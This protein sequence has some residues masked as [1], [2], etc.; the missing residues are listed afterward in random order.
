[1][2]DSEKHEIIGALLDEFLSQLRDGHQPKIDDFVARHPNYEPQIRQAFSAVLMVEDSR[3]L[4]DDERSATDPVS[5]PFGQPER[6][7]EFEIIREI[8]R[9]GMG[10][11]FEAVQSSLDRRVAIKILKWSGA[12][13]AQSARFLNEAQAAARLHHTNIVPVFQ[14][15]QCDGIHYYAMQLI[16]G[17][18]LDTALGRLRSQADS[19]NPNESPLGKPKRKTT[20]EATLATTQ[21]SLRGSQNS[22]L[23]GS[24]KRPDRHPIDSTSPP[25]S[26][27]ANFGALPDYQDRSY[28]RVVSRIVAQAAEALEYAHQS[29]VLH[30]DIKP[31]N[32]ILAAD[33]HVWLTDF[34]LAKI[35]DTSLTETG[36]IAGTLQYMAPER[37]EGI[38]NASCD[39]FSLGLTLFELITLRPVFDAPDH[40]ALIGQ[41]LRQRI[42]DPRTISPEIPTDL[43]L[44]TMKATAR[45][46]S[47]RYVSAGEFARDLNCFLAGQPISAR[48][49]TRLD[50]VALWAKRNPLVASLTTAIGLLLL[51][52][53]IGSAIAAAN[54]NQK[55]SQI[56]QQLTTEKQLLR[57]A[58]DRLLEST[59]ANVSTLKSSVAAGRSRERQD[60][61]DLAVEL[62]E[63]NPS[64]DV[65][66]LE[67][68]NMAIDTA[69]MFDVLPGKQVD[70]Q[71]FQYVPD[72]RW[73]FSSDVS[74]M[75]SIESSGDVVLMSLEE[76]NEI[77]RFQGAWAYARTRVS[78]DNRYVSVY[79]V[80]RFL[81]CRVEVW[82]RKTGEQTLADA[83]TT[84]GGILNRISFSDDSKRV[85]YLDDQGRIRVFDLAEKLERWNSDETPLEIDWV[86]LSPDGSLILFDQFTQVVCYSLKNDTIVSRIEVGQESCAGC[87]SRRRNL[88]ATST[89]TGLVSVWDLNNP[90]S[91][92]V[93]YRGHT[94]IVQAIC[95]HPDGEMLMTS[96]EDGSTRF[97]SG[98][99]LQLQTDNG[100]QRFSSDG[101][102]IGFFAPEDSFG[103]WHVK[104]RMRRV[105]APTIGT[106][107]RRTNDIAIPN[108]DFIAWTTSQ[109]Y[110]SYCHIESGMA[111][112][113]DLAGKTS[114]GI[115]DQPD[116]QASSNLLALTSA[117]LIQLPPPPRTVWPSEK[118]AVNPVSKFSN[119]NAKLFPIG[120]RE[121][122]AI[123][124]STGFQVVNI[125]REPRKVSTETWPS[126]ADGCPK[127][128]LIAVASKSQ[129]EVWF[130]RRGE[131]D[132]P[133]AVQPFTVW[134]LPDEQNGIP[135]FS[136]NGQLLV[137]ST[138]GGFL[139]TKPPTQ[140]SPKMEIVRQI[141]HRRQAF[142]QLAFTSDSKYL[143][144]NQ[145][146]KIL[147]YETSSWACVAELSA[148]GDVRFT[149]EIID[150]VG[151]LRFS[152]NDDLLIAGTDSGSVVIWDLGQ[153]RP[154]LSRNQLNW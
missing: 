50:R 48:R 14:V 124:Y 61:I 96:S 97:W 60:C 145:F 112:K 68:R 87:W 117:G 77:G 78:Q 139:V 56:S 54:I 108:D 134:K 126:S 154:I 57:Q 81:N 130:Y 9:G 136:P 4:A 63:T 64:P 46:V 113:L 146:D 144:T 69:V 19:S 38:D 12:N 115:V 129:P 103:Y 55:N 104:G 141:D 15:G 32:L 7:G 34:G 121:Y 110:V 1:M 99:Q 30:R 24:D 47:Q 52:L 147:V 122:I 37:L 43:G 3:S 17:V 88:V 82:D 58:N 118:V 105:L 114:T 132:N 80:D 148:P 153:I 11:V 49:V 31:A 2:P 133:G 92:R 98:G 40:A 75:A 5:Q 100:G 36:Q 125:G 45:D 62:V 83:G 94:S 33:Q 18:A 70:V 142:G 127:S 16:V 28:F 13:S 53:S 101:T 151:D 29:G 86:E 10:L 131:F 137:I 59:L 39:I 95:F 66:R 140:Q 149:G 25:G 73:G 116:G 23:D 102:R 35:H 84:N 107:F 65:S 26:Q 120:N 76:Q 106:G 8:G 21:V 119:N 44:I 93:D 74:W 138:F 85:A 51:A 152:R 6:I 72:Q 89:P 150:H 27:N 128:D 71:D 123:E 91:S 135:K 90:Q 111:G 42:P 79:G 109:D 143:A 41:L 67:L 20:R 22:L